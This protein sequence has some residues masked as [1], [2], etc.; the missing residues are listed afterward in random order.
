MRNESLDRRVRDVEDK[1][2]FKIIQSILPPVVNKLNCKIRSNHINGKKINLKNLIYCV[3]MT[4]A[5]CFVLCLFEL[6]DL[7]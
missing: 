5:G 3:C 4:T 6:A 2:S 7:I 1:L